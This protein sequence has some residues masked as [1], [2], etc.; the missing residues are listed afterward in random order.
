LS[1]ANGGANVLGHPQVI[2]DQTDLACELS[3]FLCNTADP[4]GFDEA[5]GKTSES[6]DVFRAIAGAYA[7]AVFIEVPIQDIVAA[8]FNAPVTTID[9]EELLGV[10]FIGF[11]AG[12]AVGDIMGGFSGLFFDRFPFDYKGLSHMRE[13]EIRV[14]L[15]GGPDFTGFDPAMIRGIIRDEIRF[16]AVLE[17]EL[18]IL[19]KSRLIAFDREVVMGVTLPV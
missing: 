2:E 18:D 3:H 4:F 16:F 11:S 5:D 10:C 7:A 6:G 13:V 12:D 14:E 19:K 15:G 8:V 1:E 17:I 9:G